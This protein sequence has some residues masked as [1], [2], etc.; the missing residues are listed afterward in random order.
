[1][2]VDYAFV[3]DYAEAK[4]KVNALGIGFDRIYAA[5]VPYKHSHFSVV[6]QLKFSRTEVGQ[7]PV[8]IHLTDADGAEVIPPINGQIAVSTPPPG[9]LENTTRL[10]MEFAGVEFKAYGDYSIRV[11]VAAQEMVSIPLSVVAPPVKPGTPPAV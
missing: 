3:C 5:K 9:I 1:V 10:V 6:V 7:K 8:Q 2:F 4:D 11:D